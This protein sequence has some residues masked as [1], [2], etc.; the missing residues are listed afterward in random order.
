[1]TTV[2]QI[3]DYLNQKAPFSLQESWD[4]S[5]L[6]VGDLKREVSR[7]LVA[8]DITDQVIEEA[9]VQ[10]A[11]LIVSH[12]PLIF[13]AAKAVTLRPDDLVGRKIWNLA[14]AGVSAICCHTSLDAVE[15]GVNTVLAQS[16]KLEN[17]TQLAQ[18]GTD[19]EGRPYGFGRIGILSEEM[20]LEEFLSL[21]QKSLAP[22]GLRYVDAGK[23]VSRVAV[24][25]GACG[26]FMMDAWKAGCDTFVTSDLKYNQFLDAKE[27]GLNLIDA[28]HFPTENIV[29]PTLT[30]WLSEGFPDVTVSV[31]RTHGEVFDYYV[32]GN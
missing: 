21:V 3:Y 16:L 26:G 12:H 24:G 17:L 8:L 11:D 7:I 28:G 18:C 5:G 2:Q 30:G 29:L 31:S 25:G 13:N 15:G 14:R 9:I 27:M 19:E 4:N 32:A 20:T 6:N 22:H 1:M 10:K 23:P